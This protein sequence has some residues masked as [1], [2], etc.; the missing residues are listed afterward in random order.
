MDWRH[1]LQFLLNIGLCQW[2]SEPGYTVELNILE[3]FMVFFHFRTKLTEYDDV[4]SWIERKYTQL[5]IS[6]DV[7]TMINTY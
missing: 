7:F 6:H 1:I 4:K 3:I 5:V 2:K